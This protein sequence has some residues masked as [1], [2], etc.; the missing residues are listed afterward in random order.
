MRFGVT[1]LALVAACG[2]GPP[3]HSSD[4]L[5]D[6]GTALSAPEC[7][8]LDSVDTWD[9]STG[10]GC[11]PSHDFDIC[12]VPNGS[13]VGSVD[14]GLVVMLADGGPGSAMCFDVCL[15]SEYALTCHGTAPD[16]QPPLPAPSFH[17]GGLRFP[18]PTPL[19][20]TIYCCPCAPR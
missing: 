9:A 11:R 2:S 16:W 13:S 18:P 8:S 15:A 12:A 10:Y 3:Q 17:C 6:A 7:P 4:T 14:G 19:G 20:T 5:A 1:I